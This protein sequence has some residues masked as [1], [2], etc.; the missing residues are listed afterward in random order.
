[1]KDLKSCGFNTS[2][3]FYTVAEIGINHGGDEDLAK[4]LIDSAARAGADSVKFQTYLTEKRVAGDSPIFDILKSCELPFEVFEELKKH[5][6]EQGVE[7][8]S[9]PFDNE[10]VQCL[11]DIGVNLYK[12]ASFDVVNHKL[13]ARIAE[14]GKTVIMSVG[15]ANLPE[16]QDAYKILKEKTER[17]AILHCVSAYPTDEKDANLSMIN[18]LKNEFDCVIGQSDHTN[19]IQ[20]PLYAATM[21]AQILEKHYKINDEMD[22][23][24]APVSIT[25]KQMLQFTEELNKLEKILGKPDIGLLDAEEGSKQFRR[26]SILNE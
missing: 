24:D 6:E 4:K 22:C 3:L 1:M 25:E 21:G 19:D 17:I 2:K 12:V 5:A 11:E 8:F 26:P 16:I 9:T 13:L 7:F 23:I 14:T 10:S 20:I 18:T 15:M